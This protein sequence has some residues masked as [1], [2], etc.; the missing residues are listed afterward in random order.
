MSAVR[1]YSGDCVLHSAEEER[2][3]KEKDKQNSLWFYLRELRCVLDVYSFK[4]LFFK[5]QA[6]TDLLN[7]YYG[8]LGSEYPFP[9]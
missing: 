9:R 3:K 7:T 2:R 6:L 8:A 1:E 5:S 4:N